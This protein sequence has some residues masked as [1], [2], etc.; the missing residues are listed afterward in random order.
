MFFN[1]VRSAD[2]LNCADFDDAYEKTSPAVFHSPN[3][4][5]ILHRSNNLIRYKL[6]ANKRKSV[7]S[8]AVSSNVGYE[9]Q[10]CASAACS[11]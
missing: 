10:F 4:S 1:F 3:H 7:Q 5:H 11:A 9:C 2:A 8:L 6:R